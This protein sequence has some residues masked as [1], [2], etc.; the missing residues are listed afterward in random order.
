MES[1]FETGALK[2][3]RTVKEWKKSFQAVFWPP[4]RYKIPVW[5]RKSMLEHRVRLIDLQDQAKVAK[6]FKGSG[7]E[8][9]Q[10]ALY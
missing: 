6:V 7:F 4:E 10:A 8:R 3:N 9:T 2:R 5:V 1:F